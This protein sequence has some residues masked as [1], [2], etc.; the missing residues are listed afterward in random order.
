MTDI[1]QHT[2]TIQDMTDLPKGGVHMEV[3][4][5]VAT[6]PYRGA[7]TLAGKFL[8]CAAVAALML[9]VS[10]VYAAGGGGGSLPGQVGTALKLEPIAGT[11]LKRVLLTAKGVD[12]LGIETAKVSEKKLVLRQMFGGQVT[13]P[14]KIEAEQKLASFQGANGFGGFARAAA[15]PAAK[16]TSFNAGA[17]APGAWIRLMLSPEEWGRIAQSK[18]ARVLPLA[19]RAMPSKEIAAK[20]SKLPPFHDL[21]RTMLAVYYF[22]PGK[23]H[24]FKVN[25][26]VR[27]ELE[28]AGSGKTFKTVPYGALYYDDKGKGWVYASFKTRV[29]ERRPI[30]VH[31]IK[32]DTAYLKEGPALGTEVV[33]TGSPLLYGAEVIYKK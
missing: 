9:A 22:V 24:G 18:S 14:L 4:Q 11:K 10:P 13:H 7:S 12:R 15:R 23:G 25:D 5:M 33:S 21:K 3:K 2:D 27:V 28:L 26:R 8:A 30:K 32:G 29:Y 20:L 1:I 16:K 19:T 31:Q 6:E 17:A